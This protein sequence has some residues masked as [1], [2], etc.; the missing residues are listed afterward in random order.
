MEHITGA[1]VLNFAKTKVLRET[2]LVFFAFVLSRGYILGGIFP[3]AVAFISY[4]VYKRTASVYLLI[5][6]A[7]GLIART[8][9]GYEPWG[10]LAAMLLCAALFVFTRKLKISLL[11]VGLISASLVI[12][13]ISVF[14]LVT[15]TV[16]RISLQELLLEAAVVFAMVL[17]L[18]CAGSF[19]L[20]HIAKSRELFVVSFTVCFIMVL[21]GANVGFLLWP[22]VLLIALTAMMQ[23][24]AGAAFLTAASGGVCAALTGQEDWG[25]MAT[26]VIGLAAAAFAKEFGGLICAGVFTAVCWLLQLADSGVVLG[27]NSYYMFVAAAL[28]II[29]N[30]KLGA[31][32]K[33]LVAPF[34]ESCGNAEVQAEKTLQQAEIMLRAEAAEMEELQELYSTYLDR[35]SVLAVQFEAMGQILENVRYSIADGQKSGIFAGLHSS[36]PRTRLGVDIAV[37]QCAASGTINGDCCGWQDIGGG[38]TAMVISDG[39]GK[40]KKAAAESLMVTR[41]IISLLK[42]GVTVELALRMINTIMI[43]KDDEDSYATVDLAIVDRQFGKAS[44]YKVGAAPTL[45]RRGENVEELTLAAVPLGIVNGLKIRYMEASVKKGDWII[46]MSDGVSDGGSDH[47]TSRNAFI[48]R[49]KAAAVKVRS[50]D[51][52]VMSELLLNQAADSYIGRERDDMTVMV[53]RII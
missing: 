37:S 35:R 41:T 17:M 46:M 30:H 29:I 16:Y 12:I 31:A 33:R 8:M 28:F 38:R 26:V 52:H 2:L 11:H 18:D 3:A 53:A 4:T 22:A 1:G 34:A 13:T 24:G 42:S 45:I 27:I 19:F 47:G 51:P 50:D 39:M 23:L 25:L 20:D 36:I 14:R 49:I 10:E 21:N 15:N 5:P 32:I 40:G 6:A 7:A 44:F 9:Q 48:D 43:V